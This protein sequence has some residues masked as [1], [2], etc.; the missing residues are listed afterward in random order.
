MTSKYGVIAPTTMPSPSSRIPFSSAIP[1]RSTSNDGAA[2]RSR[3]TGSRLCPPAMIL[4]SSP[5][6][7]NAETASSTDPGLT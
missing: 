3:S 2:S 7:A 6:S 1:P 4:A 5:P